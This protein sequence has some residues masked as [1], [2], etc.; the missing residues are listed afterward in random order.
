MREDSVIVLEEKDNS[1]EL[2]ALIAECIAKG[3]GYK[4]ETSRYLT[5]LVNAEQIT[6][7]SKAIEAKAAQYTPN[8]NTIPDELRNKE[9]SG[10]F[11][12]YR[13]YEGIEIKFILTC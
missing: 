4:G 3:Y 11:T 5:F 6:K 10:V 1:L 12:E 7:F 13:S 8:T 2:D 9:F